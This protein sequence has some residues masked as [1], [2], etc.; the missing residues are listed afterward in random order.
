VVG[1]FESG[2]VFESVFEGGEGLAFRE[3][4]GVFESVFVRVFVFE[5]ASTRV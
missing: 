5:P 3:S 2:S 1:V 4:E